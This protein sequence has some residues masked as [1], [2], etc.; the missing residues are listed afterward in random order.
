MVPQGFIDVSVAFLEQIS[1]SQ[2]GLLSTALVDSASVA[3]LE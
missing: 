3:A 2:E 1:W